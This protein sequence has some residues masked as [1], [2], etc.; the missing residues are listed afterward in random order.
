MKGCLDFPATKLTRILK[1]TTGNYIY[2]SN[3]RHIVP[4][5]QKKADGHPVHPPQ[6]GLSRPV[7]SVQ[8]EYG[9]KTFVHTRKA[10]EGHG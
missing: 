1:L 8:P 4:A 7:V 9:R 6:N 3:I 2:F 5:R 10:H